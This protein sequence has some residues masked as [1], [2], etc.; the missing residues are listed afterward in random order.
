LAARFAAGF[1]P[2]PVLEA[3]K[4]V[5]EVDTADF[6]VFAKVALEVDKE[7]FDPTLDFVAPVFDLLVP[8]ALSALLA[9]ALRLETLA[10]IDWDFLIGG[11]CPGSGSGNGHI[12]SPK[13]IGISLSAEIGASDP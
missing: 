2:R 12:D 10:L 4:L 6:E 8:V 9:N 1:A 5:F 13:M 11:F 3:D 7:A